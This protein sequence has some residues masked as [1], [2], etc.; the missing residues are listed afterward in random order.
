LVSN[1]IIAKAEQVCLKS[2][3]RY[4]MAAIIFK[5]RKIYSSGVNHQYTLSKKERLILGIPYCSIHA[6][7]DAVI[8]FTEMCGKIGYTPRNCSIYIHRQHGL[9]AKPCDKC[10]AVLKH[11]GI[12]KIYWSG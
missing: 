11:V 7:T 4:R 8:N 3:V 2:N 9:L 6:E 1:A 5:G 12:K 10:L